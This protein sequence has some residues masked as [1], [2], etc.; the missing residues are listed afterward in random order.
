MEFSLFQAEWLPMQI[1]IW[2]KFRNAKLYHYQVVPKGFQEKFSE[3]YGIICFSENLE[4]LLMWGHYA[5][6]H[7]GFVVEFD[8]NHSLFNPE[9]FGGITYSK[10][11]PI[12]EAAERM[13]HQKV[14][15]TKSIEWEYESEHRLIKQLAKLN[16]AMRRDKKEKHYVELPCKAVKAVYFGCKIP[17]ETCA[18]MLC[19]LKDPYWSHVLKFAMRRDE[20][21]YAIQP[22]PWEQVRELLAN[23]RKDFDELWKAIKL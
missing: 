22:L 10:D 14:L 20:T 2:Q 16:Q 21:K 6:S 23:A 13:Q 4:S 17:K 1:F 11:R 8:P 12:A 5:S 7:R 3:Y 19:D 9:E 18:E 15:L